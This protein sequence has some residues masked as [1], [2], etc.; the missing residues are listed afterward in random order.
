MKTKSFKEKLFCIVEA[1]LVYSRGSYS[2]AEARVCITE[3]L[4]I[5]GFAPSLFQKW[6]KRRAVLT[7]VMA[8]VNQT[9][10]KHNFLIAK[11]ELNSGLTRAS[12]SWVGLLKLLLKSIPRFIRQISKNSSFTPA[13]GKGF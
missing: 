12:V 1:R 8:R 13:K 7:P 4:G 5:R 11:V 9:R 3:A 2:M 6:F 10:L